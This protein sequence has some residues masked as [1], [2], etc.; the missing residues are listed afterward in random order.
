MERM[1]PNEM[2]M[3]EHVLSLSYGKDSTACLWAIQ[4][5]GWPL[6]RIITADVWA[7]DTIQAD[8]PPW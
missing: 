6:D 4:E 8:H 7:T 2:S 3:P 1:T 5:L